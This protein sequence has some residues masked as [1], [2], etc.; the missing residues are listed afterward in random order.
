[1]IITELL[2][3]DAVRELDPASGFALLK[4]RS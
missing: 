1:V 3:M 2:D 4:F